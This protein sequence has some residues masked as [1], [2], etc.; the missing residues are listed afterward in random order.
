[1]APP[2]GGRERAFLLRPRHASLPFTIWK[3]CR[4][5]RARDGARHRMSAGRSDLIIVENLRKAFGSA[6][7]IRGVGFVVPE[8]ALVVI[9]GPSGC[10]KS[11]LLRCLNGL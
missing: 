6:E 3:V 2:C 8:S 11:T 9:I 5:R 10:G 7:A 4:G 1:M